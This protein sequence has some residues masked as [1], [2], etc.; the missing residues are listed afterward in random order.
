MKD[1]IA[2]Y[3]DPDLLEE[4]FEQYVEYCED[5]PILKPVLFRS[6]IMAGLTRDEKKP[7]P[8]TIRGFCLFCGF[9]KKAWDTQFKMNELYDDVVHY[10]EDSIFEQQANGAAV[11]MYNTNMTIKRLGIADKVEHEV[12]TNGGFKILE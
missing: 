11:D 12:S 3:P 4:K 10:I 5:N 9:S 1:W 6:G 2:V 7:K 8:Q